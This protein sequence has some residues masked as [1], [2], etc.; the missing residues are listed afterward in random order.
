MRW[1]L[2]TAIAPVAWGANYFV[3][4]EYLPAHYALYGA[5]F[6]A[7]PAGILLLA[8][9]RKRP[10]GIWWFRAAILGALN[11]G[12]FFAL[13]YVAAQ[14]L[15]S[16]I[17]STVMATSP[18]IMMLMAWMLIGES[19]HLAS[20]VGAALG[21]TGVCLMLF[22]GP[23]SI[24]LYGLLASIAAMMMSSLGFVLAKKWSSGIDLLSLTS[25]QLIAG[26]T[27]LIP[28][29][30]AVEGSPPIPDGPAVLAYG[31]VT[32][33]ATAV[34][35]VS[36]FGGLRHLEAGTVGLIGLLNPM[37]GVL[38]GT[39][40]ASEPLSAR[41]AVGLVLVLLGILLS[42]PAASKRPISERRSWDDPPPP[43]WPPKRAAMRSQ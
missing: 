7:L 5:V 38:L 35:F 39:V 33:I 37:T 36:W 14:L 11:M 16:S 10:H 4:R 21:I 27:V 30:V 31:Y 22:S 19:L 1:V 42:R 3:T 2:I 6:R 28:A 40:L 32:V 20:L 9:S 17:A 12:I 25:W 15:P 41:Q 13:I 8:I 26:G 24:D 34:A 23:A 29:A 18:V 43:G